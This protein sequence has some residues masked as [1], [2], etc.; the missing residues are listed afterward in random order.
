MPYEISSRLHKTFVANVIARRKDLDM[1]QT[2]V[3][4]RMG[5]SQSAYAQ[6]ELG[7]CN[8]TL[9]MMERVCK[10]LK[11]NVVDA[12]SAHSTVEAA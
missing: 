3:A 5:T 6:I 11:M 10:A 1:T 9:D 12:I 7:R 4:K 2:E 8:P